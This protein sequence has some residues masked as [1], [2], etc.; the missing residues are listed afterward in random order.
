M[1]DRFYGIGESELHQIIEFLDESNAIEGVTH[2]KALEYSLNAF[3]YA[4]VSFDKLNVETILTIHKTLIRDMNPKIAGKFRQCDVWIGGE[5]KPYISDKLLEA[6]I[7]AWIKTIKDFITLVN[8]LVAIE[9]KKETKEFFAKLTH[10]EFEDIHP[11]EDGNGRVGRILF[12]V[13]RLKL[14]LPIMIIHTGEEQQNYY[15]WFRK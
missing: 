1:A 6:Q 15:K 5:K 8:S 2:P 3:N 4:L 11:F 9:L 13:L 10:I 14:G 12:N 7:E